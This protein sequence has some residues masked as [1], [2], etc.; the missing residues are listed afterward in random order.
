MVEIGDL[1][2]GFPLVN[3]SA[4]CK[5]A[6]PSPVF[7]AI[8]FNSTHGAPRCLIAAVG[9]VVTFDRVW[10]AFHGFSN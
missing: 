2:K 7:L 10:F 1:A 3:A 9:R 8:F 4:S 6:A 5:A